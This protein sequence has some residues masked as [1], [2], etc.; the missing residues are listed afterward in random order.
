MDRK[1]QLLDELRQIYAQYQREVP[2]KR[3]PWPESIRSRVQELWAMGVSCH[4]IGS[5]SRVPVQTMYSWRKRLKRGRFVA[6]P[7]PRA[8]GHSSDRPVRRLQLSQLKARRSTTVTVVLPNGIRVEGLDAPR[9]AL[10]L[11][12]FM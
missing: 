4:E 9:A 8:I 6:L 7:I 5:E 2:S 12:S 1:K 10:F 11:R 3:R